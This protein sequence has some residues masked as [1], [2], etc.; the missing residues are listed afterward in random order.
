MFDLFHSTRTT[1]PPSS[2]KKRGSAQLVLIVTCVIIMGLLALA[3]AQVMQASFGG[4]G[5]SSISLQAQ[6][7]ASAKADI[8]K[9]TTYDK[10]EPQSK[11]TITNSNGFQDAVELSPEESYSDDIKQRTATIRVFL[12]EE[13][14]PRY[15]LKVLRLSKENTATSVPIGTVII[16]PTFNNPDDGV[17]LLCNGQSCSAYPE[18]VKVLGKSTVPNYQGV[19]LRGY[20]SQVSTHYGN[21]THS[22]GNIGELQGDSIR[23]IYGSWNSGQ[24]IWSSDGAIYGIKNGSI[25][26]NDYYNG[27]RAYLD[28]SRVVPVANENRPINI[29]VRYLI[30]AA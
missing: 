18:L 11:T 25:E 16:W 5:S 28:A 1:T 22:S 13:V 7:Y 3:N 14:K 26:N 23:N 10:L 6:Q 8:I 24:Y 9:A 21:V 2:Y 15:S 19:F 27:Y 30:K 17:W 20:G 4:L 29:A 12:G